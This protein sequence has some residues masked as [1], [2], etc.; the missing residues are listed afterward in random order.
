MSLLQV[1]HQIYIR[2]RNESNKVYVASRC[3]GGSVASKTVHVIISVNPQDNLKHNEN[4]KVSKIRQTWSVPWYTICVKT[5]HST[6]RYGHPPLSLIISCQTF[7]SI[8]SFATVKILRDKLLS[9]WGRGTVLVDISQ[10]NYYFP[11]L[12]N[13][14]LIPIF[15]VKCS[16]M[17]VLL[18]SSDYSN[19]GDPLIIKC[20]ELNYNEQ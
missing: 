7:P 18:H 17:S 14:L 3:E 2:Q 10:Q 6:L 8:S 16:L 1:C 11:W 15:Q 20:G 12:L 4:K 5:T 13:H 9:R 19:K